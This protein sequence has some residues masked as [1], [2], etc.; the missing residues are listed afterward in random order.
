MLIRKLPEELEP[1]VR[2]GVDRA[3]EAVERGDYAGF[4]DSLVAAIEPVRAAGWR[5]DDY[6]AALGAQHAGAF[7]ALT[8]GPVRP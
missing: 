5:I 1:H 6:I 8:I 2:R 4:L 7:P 3:L